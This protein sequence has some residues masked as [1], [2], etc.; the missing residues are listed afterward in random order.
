MCL[1]LL[2]GQDLKEG[3]V[4]LCF[5][6]SSGVYFVSG[7]VEPEVGKMRVDDVAGKTCYCTTNKGLCFW[8]LS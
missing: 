5:I 3:D 1:R 6:K 7:V 2:R 4:V 8:R